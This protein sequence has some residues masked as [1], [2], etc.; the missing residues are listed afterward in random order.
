[1]TP[2]AGA[3]PWLAGRP[4]YD[5][6][7]D[8]VALR[9]R[10][11]PRL[12]ELGANEHPAGPAPAARAA[13]A[14]ALAGVHRY[15]DPRAGELRAAL[16]AR[17]GI[18]GAEIVFGN[19]SHELLMQLG[20]A[21]SGPG[22]EVVHSRYGFAVFALAAGAAGA[23][24]VCVEALPEEHPRA[25]LGHDLERLAAAVTPRTTLVFLA[26]PNNPTGTWFEQDVL[27]R[28]LAAVPPAVLVV[29]DEA[30]AEYHAH[31]GGRSALE[32][33]A[34]FP[35]LVVTRT[36]SK[37][38]ALAGLR[39]GWLAADPEVCA[40]LEVLRENFNVGVPAQAAARA[41][42]DADDWMA[43]CLADNAR[44][45]ERLAAGLAA[46]GY[47]CLPSRTNFLLMAC[48]G[49]AAPLEARL[50]EQGIVLR[51]VG[52]YGLARHLRVT[53]GRPDENTRLLDALA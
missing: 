19:G 39:V 1:M 35:N 23:R 6:G 25:P 28:F 49:P 9:R 52:A 38:H 4:A 46:R 11:G 18:S 10:F 27:R 15:P 29:V 44:E 13:L 22:S 3:R 51:P 37:A 36:F 53:V 34:E 24:G 5:P 40:V 32:L 2:G 7:H 48:G 12:V 42:L 17:H 47:P 16:A 43:A 30:Y 14:A 45:R 8:L 26:N 21:F 41:S 20:Q 50:V 33:R 31:A